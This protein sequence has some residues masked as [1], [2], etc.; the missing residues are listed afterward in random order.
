MHMNEKQACLL[1]GD[2]VDGWVQ[3]DIN[4]IIGSLSDSCKIIESHGPTYTGKEQ[5]KRWAEEWFQTGKVDE[6]SIDSFFYSGIHNTAFFEW[7]F[8]CTIDGRTDSFEGASVFQFEND[9]ISQLHE[10][11]MTHPAFDY[12]KN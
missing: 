10:Y 6:W 1:V 5:V 9:K 4:R 7:K 11:R 12:F 2:Y 3:A 8:T